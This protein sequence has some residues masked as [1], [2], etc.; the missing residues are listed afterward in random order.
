MLA[1]VLGVTFAVAGMTSPRGRSHTFDVRADGYVRGEACCGMAL[2]C[3]GVDGS[4]A[5]A[6]VSGCAVRQDGRSASLTAPN[7]QAQQGL[8]RAALMEGAVTPAAL[9][10]AEAHGTGTALGDPIE[11]GSL[12]AA[13]LSERGADSGS[14]VV[15]GVK[16]SIGHA[17][18]SAGLTGVARLALRLK[19]RCG[20]ANAQLRVLNPHV[21]GAAR[22]TAYWLLVG[23]GTLGGEYDSGGVS[24]FGYSGTIAHAALQAMDA[25]L[26]SPS[27]ALFFRRC[28]FLWFPPP[29]PLLQHRLPTTSDRLAAFRSPAAG[30]LHALVAHHVVCR[31][32]VLP[33]AAYLEL[34]RAACCTGGSTPGCRLHNVFFLHPL[35][36]DSAAGAPLAW[37][38]CVWHA[39]C[40]TFKVHRREAGVL[41]QDARPAH[42]TGETQP[43]AVVWAAPTIGM[44]SRRGGCERAASV[45]AQY[46][47]FD[48]VGL[49]YGPA[50]R[51]LKWAWVDDGGAGGSTTAGAV[52]RLREATRV[53]SIVVHPAE[54]DGALQLNAVL[55]PLGGG[56]RAETQLPFAVDEAV[57]RG[58]TT[59]AHA[60]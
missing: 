41:D 43:A 36:L 9:V 27:A 30:P 32:V 39:E 56:G 58:G 55:A 18:P 51:K 7:G 19:E 53:E 40:G 33:G 20:A 29:H 22:A 52:A 21:R 28:A 5:A 48:A 3:A 38:E 11:V 24:S 16:A 2:A 14:L 10:A 37:V 6:A 47:G 31:R 1:P 59:K 15:G 25:A 46:A 60:V 8:L 54:L 44:V 50:Y 35:V 57:L 12:S 13:V 49:A 23:V 42:C 45:R 26:W 34:A 17:E 4:E